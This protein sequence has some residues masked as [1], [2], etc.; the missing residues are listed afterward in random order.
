MNRGSMKK[1]ILFLAALLPFAACNIEQ[2]EEPEAE[3]PV[4]QAY[5]E[6]E[7]KTALDDQ[8]RVLWSKDDMV[9]VFAG[10][11]DNLQYKATSYGSTYTDLEAVGNGSTSGTSMLKNIAYYPYDE[12]VSLS[13]VS[14]SIYV[15]YVTIPEV[16]TYQQGSCGNGAAPMVAFTS[17]TDEM[18][19]P[20]K[21]L[22]GMVNINLI[23]TAKI[24]KITFSGNNGELLCGAA[25]VI[26]DTPE[27]LV[28][29]KEGKTVTLDCGAGVQLDPETP[30]SFYIVLPPEEYPDG[31][32]AVVTDTEGKS[33]SL[34]SKNNHRI[35]RSKILNMQIVSYAGTDFIDDPANC[36]IVASEGDYSFSAVKGNSSE[37]V[38]DVVSAEVLW[39]S[40][41]TGTAPSKG[42]LV[43]DVSYWNGRICFHATDKKGNALIAAKDASGNILWS[44]HIWL[45]DKPAD[46]TYDTNAGAG[47][48]MDRNLGATSATPGDV[49]AL[50]LMYQWGRK[51][52]FPGMAG[53]TSTTRAA[54]SVKMPDSVASTSTTGTVAY[55]IAHPTTFISYTDDAGSRYDWKYS[56]DDT[57]WSGS[58]KTVY[59]PC[60]AGYRLP[61]GG[62]SGQWSKALTGGTGNYF[63]TSNWDSTNHGI[64]FTQTGRK[65]GPESEGCIWYPAAGYLDEY[66]SPAGVGNTGRYWSGTSGNASG[67][68]SANSYGL[69]F[70]NTTAT[71]R[72]DSA[73]QELRIYGQSVRCMAE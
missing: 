20:F 22:C 56:K 55:T 6:S 59:D 53:T 72:V 36:Y 23:G 27:I 3:S 47:V 25:Q 34:L 49:E 31:F 14:N 45:T 63:N 2:I 73:D 54:T 61:A 40:F 58:E 38:G 17:S 67:G 70:T 66:E 64:D 4:F 57:L 33:M 12:S 37:S 69:A 5:M 30:T 50:G 32:T 1:N 18:K 42:S 13:V 19:L 48:W 60:P 52:P 8:S 24:S 26:P 11:T 39:E 9:S 15:L 41:G 7:T 68:S 21:N 62:K 44:W 35:E 29:E 46:Q 16:Q 71:P 51:D 65:L 10:T 43:S 28:V